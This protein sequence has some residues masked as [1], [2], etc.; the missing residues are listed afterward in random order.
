LRLAEH[1]LV[2]FDVVFRR[3][4]IPTTNH[5]GLIVEFSSG[6][7]AYVCASR[8]RERRDIFFPWSKGAIVTGIVKNKDRPGAEFLW[9]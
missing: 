9:H 8:A 6:D 1:E 7:K 4:V 3:A 5:S 2:V